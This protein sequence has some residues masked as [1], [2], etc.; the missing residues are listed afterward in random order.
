M[1]VLIDENREQYIL[2]GKAEFI[3]KSMRTNTE[4]R[5]KVKKK[6]DVYLVFVAEKEV[7]F[8]YAG[9]IKR[10][11]V[12]MRWIYHRGN[13]GNMSAESSQIKALMWTLYNGDNKQVGVF[14]LGRC[15]RCG[16]V[17]K[18]EES[19]KCGLGPECRKKCNN[20]IR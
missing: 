17:L 10:D 3:L 4:Y 8:I 13:K 20:G 2:G 11:I 6:E 19:I 1:R 16:R 12:G 14:H 15:G 9:F 18:D 5:Y 7:G